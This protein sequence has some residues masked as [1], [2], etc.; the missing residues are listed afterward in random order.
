MFYGTKVYEIQI[1]LSIV[2]S[3]HGYTPLF[4]VLSM[5]GFGTTI[6]EL[7]TCNRSYMAHKD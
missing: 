5:I 1:S 2:L 3:R 7:S 6:T 4:E